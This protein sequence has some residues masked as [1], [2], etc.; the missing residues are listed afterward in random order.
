MPQKETRSLGARNLGESRYLMVPGSPKQRPFQTGPPDS[1]ASHPRGLGL[2]LL[3][4]GSIFSQVRTTEG[5]T[6]SLAQNSL[7]AVREG[8]HPGTPLL[9]GLSPPI[10]SFFACDFPC[11]S[12]SVCD[13]L[14]PASSFIDTL[15]TVPGA[16][17]RQSTPEPCQINTQ[18]RE[19]VRGL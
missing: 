2:L 8:M 3:Q 13:W 14:M 18:G 19:I 9:S 15:R 16:L 17:G 4:L 12:R 11:L 5:Q 1:G 10:L 7:G 6:A